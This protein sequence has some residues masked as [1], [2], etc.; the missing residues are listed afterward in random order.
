MPGDA[1]YH[2]SSRDVTTQL[3]SPDTYR[4]TADQSHSSIQ[5]SSSQHLNRHQRHTWPQRTHQDQDQA[6]YILLKNLQLPTPAEAK[7]FIP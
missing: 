7:L 3:C 5:I 2:G 6:C 1:W 4:H